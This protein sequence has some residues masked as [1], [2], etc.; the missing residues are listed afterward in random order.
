MCRLEFFWA[1]RSHYNNKNKNQP[2]PI[3]TKVQP[4]VVDENHHGR[5]FFPQKC[6]CKWRYTRE[7]KWS[8]DK[9][10]GEEY[11]QKLA[12][13]HFKRPLKQKKLQLTLIQKSL[14]QALQKFVQ[15]PCRRKEKLSNTALDKKIM[16]L[17]IKSVRPS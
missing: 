10:T 1:N 11:D 7:K 13:R 6:L 9:C 3:N 12:W 2:G 5:Q 8:L 14:L 4:G 16:M 15:E 17:G